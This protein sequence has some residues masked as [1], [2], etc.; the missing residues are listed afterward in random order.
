MVRVPALDSLP[1]VDTKRW[2][3]RRKAAVLAAVQRGL[4]SREEAFRRYELSEEE[5]SSW[6]RSY[7]TYGIDGLRVTCLRRY[8]GDRSPRLAKAASTVTT[9]TEQG[10]TAPLE[11]DCSDRLR[12]V[13][14]LE[15]V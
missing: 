7:E 11:E 6:Q 2:V 1:A 5:F 3:A 10:S 12:D 4:I 13:P 14:I 15:R 9:V 8:R